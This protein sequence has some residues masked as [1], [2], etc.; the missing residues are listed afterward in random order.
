MAKEVVVHNH[1]GVSRVTV[2]LARKWNLGNYENMDLMVGLSDDAKVGE[3]T[4]DAI[5]RVQNVVE[6]EFEKI[7]GKLE[8]TA[9]V[10]KKGG[11]K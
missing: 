7:C 2:S 9:S 3:S 11:K 4:Q 1:N 5:L 8:G 6:G 10:P